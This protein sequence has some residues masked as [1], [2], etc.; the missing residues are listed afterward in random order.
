MRQVR[1]LPLAGWQT[2]LSQK[3]LPAGKLASH[4]KQCVRHVLPA[5]HQPAAAL[6]LH[7]W[8]PAQPVLSCQRMAELECHPGHSPF[9]LP[10]LLAGC[11]AQV[12]QAGQRQTVCG[13][14][15][16]AAAA[17]AGVRPR[18]ALILAPGSRLFLMVFT[19]ALVCCL[20]EPHHLPRPSGRCAV[21][22]TERR[23]RS[24]PGTV[25][26]QGWPHA[27][28]R[29]TQLVHFSLNSAHLQ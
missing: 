18:P 23:S 2:C 6:H 20:P 5:P 17:G 22:L 3:P 11:P 27:L 13:A 9:H 12:V 24:H 14:A 7:A 26:A 28:L 29:S 25:S 16:A 15:G 8:L 10:S 4:R 21:A 19:E 1:V